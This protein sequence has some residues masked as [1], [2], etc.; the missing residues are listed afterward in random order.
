MICCENS[1]IAYLKDLS[2]FCNPPPKSG[3]SKCGNRPSKSRTAPPKSPHSPH[4]LPNSAS[5]PQFWTPPI[6][7]SG[8]PQIKGISVTQKAKDSAQLFPYLLIFCA[9]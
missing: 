3:T 7:N 5:H 2:L 9:C 4:S 6:P 8:F 1:F